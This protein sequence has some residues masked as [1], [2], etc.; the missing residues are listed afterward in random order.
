MLRVGRERESL[1]GLLLATSGPPRRTPRRNHG[2]TLDG[3]LGTWSKVLGVT[4]TTEGKTD[5]RQVF[6]RV[7]EEGLLPDERLHITIVCPRSQSFSRQTPV[8]VV[9]RVRDA[10]WVGCCRAR[11][12]NQSLCG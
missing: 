4:G 2:E 6:A 12:E 9:I 5:K 7:L 3:C 11:K 10:L 1:S 8:R